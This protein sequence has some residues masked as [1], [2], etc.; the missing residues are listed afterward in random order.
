MNALPQTLETTINSL[1]EGPSFERNEDTLRIL[2][3]F[4]ASLNAGSARVVERIGSDWRINLWVKRGI[5]LHLL[6]G[7]LT[8]QSNADTAF[9]LDTLPRRRL[10]AADQ[11][12]AP[13]TCYIRDG[14]YL[15]AGVTCMPHCFV[16][17]GAYVGEGTLIDSHASVG[18]CAQ[19]GRS[20][21]INAG[22]H[23]GGMLEPVDQLPNIIGDDVVIGCNC[24]V[25]DGVYISEGAIL[26]SG[27][28]ITRHSRIFDPVNKSLYRAA[29]GQPLIVPPKAILVPG[30]QTAIS[31][32]PLSASGL[33]L[34]V[35][36]IAGYRD[37]ITPGK[38]LL[39]DLLGD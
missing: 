2:E 5:L 33:M 8:E 11:I 21:R 26:T 9:E 17:L 38:D 4:R 36:V 22:S 39:G 34:Q 12:R 32:G 13:E 28:N 14:A 27:V 35:L 3:E 1:F 10:K 18:V 24:G 20:V 15:G 29:P 25:F 30:T 31:D 16:N 19:V 6:A 7:Q 23:I 37:Q